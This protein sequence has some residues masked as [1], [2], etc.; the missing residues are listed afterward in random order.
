MR[1]EAIAGWRLHDLPQNVVKNQRGEPCIRSIVT[2][3]TRGARQE[4]KA[5]R[6]DF[7]FEA[8]I[9]Q[10]D[11]FNFE[12]TKELDVFHASLGSKDVSEGSF[13]AGVKRVTL[14]TW[15]F[16]VEL[17]RLDVLT[18]ERVLKR[19]VECFTGRTLY[20]CTR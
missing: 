5:W 20:K 6:H 9:T 15:C 3:L 14:F 19:N 1:I 18:C 11:C 16:H 8:I 17:K 12:A 10:A 4:E 13:P 7:C 2:A